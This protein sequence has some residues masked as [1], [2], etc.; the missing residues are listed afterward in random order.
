MFPILLE[1]GPVVIRT[2]NVLMV[3]A[4]VA[5]AFIFWRKTR[6][7]HYEEVMVFDG[8]LLS[9]LFGLILSRI[10]FI[11]MR[12][13]EFGSQ[14]WHWFDLF[15]HP[16]FSLYALA[17]GATFYLYRYSVKKKWDAFEILDFWC[18]ALSLGLSIIWLGFFFE[19]TAFG[20]PTSLPWGV[21]FPGVLEKHHPA[22]LYL[23]IFYFAMYLYLSWVEYRYR[24][25]NWYRR[26]KNTAYTGFL[27]SVFL[28][29]SGL[30]SLALSW[31]MLPSMVWF[32]VNGEMILSLVAT[33]AGGILLYSRSQGGSVWP[34]GGLFSSRA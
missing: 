30:F 8:F 33:M 34:T 9:I 21:T 1:I 29:F 19:G 17:A 25:F 13:Q 27:I 14:I 15:G 23:A 24:T 5:T 16:G 3:I 32:G 4:F 20:R 18:M 31:I 7:E 12:W 28:L 2:L 11:V 10:M 6:E 26:G 22:Q